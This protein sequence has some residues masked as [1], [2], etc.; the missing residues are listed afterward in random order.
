MVICFKTVYSLFPRLQLNVQLAGGSS[1]Q[2]DLSESDLRIGPGLR[3]TAFVLLLQLIG[4]LVQDLP[5]LQVPEVLVQ[6]L[7]DLTRLP[8][9]CHLLLFGAHLLLYQLEHSV[10]GFI[11]IHRL[12]INV[13]R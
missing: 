6:H 3:F 9:L 10:V 2:V 11:L 12:E 7:L 5:A 13:D 4:Q 1:L 8:F